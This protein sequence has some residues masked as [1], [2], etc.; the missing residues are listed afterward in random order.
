[1]YVFPRQRLLVE[2]C[3]SLSLAVTVINDISE[4]SSSLALP[5]L[6]NSQNREPVTVLTLRESTH[7]LELVFVGV[8]NSSLYADSKHFTNKQWTQA[9]QIYIW[10]QILL[11]CSAI[12]LINTS[13]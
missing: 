2:S 13:I 10:L 3:H 9:E 6:C 1:M 5:Y 7:S 8:K 11:Y 4:T 12:Y